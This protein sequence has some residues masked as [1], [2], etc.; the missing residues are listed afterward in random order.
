MSGEAVRQTVE[1]VPD[2]QAIA[3]YASAGA[4]AAFG[5]L[6]LQEWGI[7]VGIFATVLTAGVNWWYKRKRTQ[8][9]LQALEAAR[10]AD[11]AKRAHFGRRR[12][13]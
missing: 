13:D 12:D 3:S 9:E 8:A 11:E 4:T 10:E 5:A 6:T 1:T 2:K 7:I